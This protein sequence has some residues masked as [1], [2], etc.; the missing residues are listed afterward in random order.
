MS[1]EN[2]IDSDFR[3]CTFFGFTI[4][5]SYYVFRNKIFTAIKSMYIAD[6]RTSDN[7]TDKKNFE[8]KKSNSMARI[9]I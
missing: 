3:C 8:K 2:N 7:I 5:G 1:C 9:I 4:F 6:A